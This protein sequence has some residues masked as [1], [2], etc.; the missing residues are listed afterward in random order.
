MGLTRL[1]HQKRS[2]LR[3]TSTQKVTLLASIFLAA[4]CLYLLSPV[5]T[6]FFIALFLAY[7]GNPLVD[8]LQRWHLPRTAGVGIV[9]S[10]IITVL[11][12][13]IGF[14]VPLLE[15][16]VSRLLANLPALL[17]WVQT[18][19]IP[20]LTTHFG[21][22]PLETKTFSNIVTEHWQQAGNIA[23]IAWKT[24]SNSSLAILSWVT[25]L[26]LIPVV[27]FYFLRDWHH[28]ITSIQTLLPRNLE[29][30]ISALFRE[31]N[32]V[33]SAFFRGQL[34][35]MLILTTVYS[36]GLSI[37]GLDLA[38]LIGLISGLFAIVPYLGLAIGVI[39]ASIAAFAQF[40]DWLHVFYVWIVFGLATVLENT[41]LTPVLVGDRIG[42]HPVA[43]LFAIFCGGQLFGFLGVLL[44]L[45][46]A[47]V[48]MVLLRH[49]R[50]QYIH[51]RVYTS[52]SA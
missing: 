38:L 2:L 46:V 47:A 36:L 17:D 16:Q 5:L 22:A 18:I 52:G 24:V 10:L 26:F 34:L 31:F 42:L 6:P 45:P 9:F 23:S 20:W 1:A 14:L 35:V 44:A 19:V 27:T 30:F 39:T 48:T 8:Q 43:V 3:M 15:H 13:L 28:F 12:L 4:A 37:V 41:V 40:Q 21:L 50:D 29:A 33:L 7:L 11:L 51:S 25:N 49:L 32:E